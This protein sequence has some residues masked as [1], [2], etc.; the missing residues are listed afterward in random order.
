MPGIKRRKLDG[1][2]DL[3]QFQVGS[4]IRIK[5]VNFM[6]YSLA[7]FHFGPQ[8]NLILGPNG[9]GKSTF[10]CAICIGL[11]GKVDYLGK[12][13]MKTDQ[14][15]K[16]DEEEALIQIELKGKDATLLVEK[17][18][19]R[20]SKTDWLVNGISYTEIGMRK[21]LKDY[22]IQ[23][24]NLCQFLPQDRVAR[25]ASLKPEELLKEIERLY[26]QGELLEQH[27]KL[28]AVYTDVVDTQRTLTNL[29]TRQ[30]DLTA[31]HEQLTQDAQK[32]KEYMKLEETLQ[33]LKEV[34]EY[35][36]LQDLKTRRSDLK[37]DYTDKNAELAD[38][39]KKV[40]PWRD[41][42]NNSRHTVTT[43]DA[44]IAKLSTQESKL[45][46]AIE[47]KMEKADK[48]IKAIEELQ[49]QKAYSSTRLESLTKEL[50]GARERYTSTKE[51][52]AKI[53]TLNEDQVRMIEADGVRL[54]RQMIELQERSQENQDAY[55]E[56]QQTLLLTR[57]DI[58]EKKSQLQSTDRLVTLDDR[59]WQSV[60]KCVRMLREQADRNHITCF[61]PAA[62]SITPKDSKCAPA[63]E[64][65]IRYSNMSAY[66]VTNKFE[67]DKLSHYLYD[68]HPEIGR[69]MGLR[70][71]AEN[72]NYKPKV[73][74]E[75][76]EA[77]GF[78]G[79]LSDFLDGPQE[80]VR[81]LCETEGLHEVPIAFDELSNEQLDNVMSLIKRGELPLRRMVV[82]NTL[83]IFNRS[84]HGSRQL[85]TT[86]RGIP[87]RVNIF[88]DNLSEE[89]SEEANKA[90]EDLERKIQT[91]N[92]DIA[93]LSVQ[94]KAD[95]PE[96][97]SVKN[98]LD[99]IR[100]QLAHNKK[101]QD[102][103]DDYK[104]RM[105]T[106]KDSIEVKRREIT[107]LKR[108]G[109]QG[110]N[111]TLR[112]K[113][114][115]LQKKRVLALAE[116]GDEFNR[117]GKLGMD[118]IKNMVLKIQEENRADSIDAL[119]KHISS[120]QEKLES[121]IAELRQQRINLKAQYDEAARKYK[122]RIDGY[123]DEEKSQIMLKVE[124]MRAKN[125]LSEVGVDEEIKRISS[126]MQLR[127]GSGG[128]SIR[129][130]QENE[131]ALEE[132]KELIPEKRLQLA[133]SKDE[134]ESIEAEWRPELEKVVQKISVDFADNL[135]GVA[136]AGDV[137]LDQES[138]N[139]AEWKLRILV[140]FRDSEQMVQL[141]AA[142]QSG[143][144]KSV[145]TAVFLN[146]LQGLANVPFRIVDE[147][148]QGMDANNERKVHKMIV[149]KS[150]QASD[151][152]QYFLI[153][154]KLLTNLYYSEKMMVHCIFA[155]RWCPP[156]EDTPKFLE[157]G[158][159]SHYA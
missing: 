120:K 16:T 53:D 15:I 157:M 21:F 135:K 23:L 92:N 36:S 70:T 79:Y 45:R 130:L 125:V 106:E 8:M 68:Q 34:R 60:K 28:C 152:A 77:L 11:A 43:T 30:A 55:H 91:L 10:V 69:A 72:F 12:A 103:Y 118:R 26:E 139:F 40:D 86:A 20:D 54:N 150:E 95:N 117:L 71:L 134:M 4:I 67:Y 87:N 80:V 84:S 17:P 33:R 145:T 29:E 97:T 131:R 85:L 144:E 148:N 89:E 31:K 83:H 57:K 51:Q 155:G 153:T 158:E 107:K 74:R 78:D 32:W 104:T 73:S 128:F 41:T 5:L 19:V 62:I 111:E 151:A 13:G 38:L 137:R 133:Q 88:K 123:S 49:K 113:I 159:F 63:L 18:L 47:K 112:G 115:E 22:R 90:I 146:S 129:T 121:E 76:I 93:G 37:Q 124:D 7:E 64:T 25:F 27:N 94:L 52:L 156:S 126:T 142:Q 149:D 50:Q 138:P 65:I 81:M 98:E 6:S 75:R 2:Q 82:K 24:S 58:D 96:I 116:V 1:P 9:S 105:D 122:E 136:N 101:Q 114:A 39:M 119:S 44:K 141:N 14:F 35:A 154:P 61:E 102:R 3:A 127:R 99:E 66:T 109:S 110:T 56:K 48:H 132:L 147:I 46:A 59:R 100:S 42:I 108:H 140:S 143:G